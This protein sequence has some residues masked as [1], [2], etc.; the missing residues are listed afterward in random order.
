MK[1]TD[2]IRKLNSDFFV[3]V[4]DSQLKPLC[5]Y[6]LDTY[7]I[8]SKHH[9]IAANEGNCIGIA[10]GYHLATGKTPVVYLQNSGEGNIVNPILS[11]SSEKVYDLPLIL[12][13]GWR[14]E[15]GIPDEPQHAHQGLVTLDLL[16]TMDFETH[17]IRKETVEIPKLSRRSALVICKGSLEY[18]SRSYENSNGINRETAIKSILKISRNDV[19]VSTT[20]KISREVFENRTDHSHDFLTVGSMGHASSIALGIAIQ[21]PNRKIW[22]LDGDGSLLMHMGSLAILGSI[23]PQNLIHV[24]LN[25]GSHESVGGMPTVAKSLDLESIARGSGY[26]IIRRIDREEDLTKILEEVRSQNKLSF[27]E[28]RCS[29]GSRKNLGRPTT[30]PLENKLAF[31]KFLE[32]SD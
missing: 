4:P 17:I 14:G 8:D 7:G 3:G 27:I 32:E 2:L 13:I 11:L 19:I 9:I 16:E 31:M 20:G 1:V 10:A 6:L 18:E 26:E 23:K 28:I 24:V 22:C 30:S 25:N 29:I 5:S 12:I 21:K 15:P